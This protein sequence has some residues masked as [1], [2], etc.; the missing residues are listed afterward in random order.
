[1]QRII[2][3][4]RLFLLISAIKNFVCQLTLSGRQIAHNGAKTQQFLYNHFIKDINEDYYA[5]V[6][7]NWKHSNWHIKSHH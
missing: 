4:L 3:L 1:M 6:L 5:V 7:F 2:S